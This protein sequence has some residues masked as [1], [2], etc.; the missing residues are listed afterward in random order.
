MAKILIVEDDLRLAENIGKWLVLEK[1]VV[2]HLEDGQEATD[3][4][5]FYP[6]DLIILDWGLPGVSGIEVLRQYRSHGGIA[7]V[8]MLT[9]RKE[10]DEK[11]KGLD[12][13]ADDYLT[14]PF[15][16]RELGARV[17]ALLRRPPE[18][19]GQTLRFGDLTL[20]T[21][22]HRVMKGD[23]EIELL[24]KEFALLQFLMRHPGQVFSPEAIVDRV[25][26]SISEVSPESV[27][28]YVTRLRS[29]IGSAGEESVIKN[30]HGV[31]YRL[32]D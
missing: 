8:L 1:H 10:V 31:G 25:W 21:V 30:I 17:R 18:H 23:Q 22:N 27:R 5:R 12:A 16:M 4:L 20:D 29:K 26:A 3:H 7:P 13:G 15:H 6:Y 19:P 2:E 28:T 9:G 32:G 14:K 24:P 11:E